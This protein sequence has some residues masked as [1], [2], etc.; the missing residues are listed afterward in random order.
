MPSKSPVVSPRPAH[1][2]GL[3]PG[4]QDLLLSVLG[5]CP[6]KTAEY[7]RRRRMLASEFERTEGAIDKALAKLIAGCVTAPIAEGGGES[8]RPPA[9]HGEDTA[10]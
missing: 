9:G 3:T 4:Q 5:H 10:S 7:R 1:R 2:P 6:R 8:V